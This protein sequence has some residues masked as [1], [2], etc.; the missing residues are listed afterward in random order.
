MPKKIEPLSAIEV[1]RIQAPGTHAV[2]GVSGLL[3]KVTKAGSRQWI[4]RVRV[5]KKRRDIGLGGFPDVPLAQARSK[6][7]EVR[8]QVQQGIDPVAEREAARQALI[9]AQAKRLSFAEAARRKHLAIQS[10]FRNEKHRKDWLS[11][12]ERHAFPVLGDIDVAAIELPHVLGVLQPIWHT[13]TETATR[14]RQRLESVLAWAIVS[15]YRDGANPAEWKN[16]LAEV[17]PAPSKIRKKRHQRAL[18]WQ[19]VPGFM[20]GLRQRNGTGARALEFAILTAA[21]SGEVRGM[22]WAEID[23]AA[24]MWTVPGTHTKTGRPHTVPLPDRAMAII[25]AQPRMAGTEY[26]FASSQGKKLSDMSLSAVT[27]RMGVDAVPHGF[28]SSFKDWARNRTSFADEVS[29]LAL[30]HVNSDATRAAYARDEL[31]PQ[32][33]RLMRQWAQFCD[34]GDTQESATVTNIG[35]VRA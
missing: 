23:L 3:L 13:R 15:G 33:A 30:A 17:L 29:E 18:P 6:A 19:E 20:A 4:L 8:E 5:G 7:R 31:L 16:N 14:V 22:E 25:T 27:K 12:L 11:A 28:R 2:G 10:Q 32:R 34:E 35:E 9:A 26:V 1:K 24:Q 21:R